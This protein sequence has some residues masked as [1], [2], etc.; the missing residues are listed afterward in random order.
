MHSV[1][2]PVIFLLHMI[3]YE[4]QENIQNVFI[5]H[6]LHVINMLSYDEIKLCM[7]DIIQFLP[8]FALDET[9]SWH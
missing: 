6:A 7:I 9:N 4:L 3:N 8:I 1:C 2:A 5:F